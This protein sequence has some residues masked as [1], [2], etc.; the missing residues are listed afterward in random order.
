VNISALHFYSQKSAVYRKSQCEVMRRELSPN[1]WSVKKLPFSCL[2]WMMQSFCSPCPSPSPR[3]RCRLLFE[4][5][6]WTWMSPPCLQALMLLCPDMT[7]DCSVTEGC[8]RT[9][10]CSVE[11]KVFENRAT[12]SENLSFSTVSSFTLYLKT[13]MN[14]WKDFSEGLMP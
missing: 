1:L 12:Q 14:N 6:V 13:D 2:G 7:S 4:L 3:R 8:M 9:Q 11:R 10:R 5:L